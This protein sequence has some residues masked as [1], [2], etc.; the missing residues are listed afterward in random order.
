M[1]DNIKMGVKGIGCEGIDS[2]HLAQD[3][4]QWRA[5]VNTVMDL[6]FPL[7]VGNFLTFLASISFQQGLFSMELAS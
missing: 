5:L 1:G 4:D 2:I 3:T 6:Q 7:K